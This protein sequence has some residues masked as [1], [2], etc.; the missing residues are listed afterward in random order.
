MIFPKIIE[1]SGTSE[2]PVKVVKTWDRKIGE[3]AI[4]VNESLLIVIDVGYETGY[5]CFR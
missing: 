3:D 4:I 1:E 2:E 5:F